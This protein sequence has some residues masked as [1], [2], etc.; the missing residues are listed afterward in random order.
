MLAY[1]KGYTEPDPRE[2]LSGLDVARK[3]V[4]LAREIGLSLELG[5]VSVENLTPVELI[6]CS[7]AIFFEQIK[8]YDKELTQQL[9]TLQGKASALHFIGEVSSHG[10]ASVAVMALEKNSPFV[11]LSGADNMVLIHSQR[12][13]H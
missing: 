12:Y 11:S 13:C 5:D 8:N 3:V 10:R 9:K 4:C 1:Q 7:K 2:D 6:S